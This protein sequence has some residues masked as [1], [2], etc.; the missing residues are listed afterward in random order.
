MM[1]LL[2]MADL[3]VT[4]SYSKTARVWDG[5]QGGAL[6]HSRRCG[7]FT[8]SMASLIIKA[9]GN[10][11]KTK[12]LDKYLNRIVGDLVS[13]TVDPDVSNCSAGGAAERGNRL[14]PLARDWYTKD[15]CGFPVRETGFIYQSPE[16]VCG[17]S[18]DGVCADRLIE[19]KCLNR[20]NH[21]GAI[22]YCNDKN[23][24]PPEFG[25]QIQMN[26]WTTGM[27]KLDLIFFT[28]SQSLPCKILTVEADTVA[29]KNL[30]KLIPQF[31]E[32]AASI[33]EKIK[34]DGDFI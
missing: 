32:E 17:I 34:K 22:R 11:A 10:P 5:A 16:L 23:N 25:P 27:S 20:S 30:D 14:E 19:I 18:P 28:P 1:T 26:M 21:I 2:T 12:S 4:A 7:C 24:P 29:H 31:T 33:A 3:G 6:W 8:G 13:G 15:K 9:D